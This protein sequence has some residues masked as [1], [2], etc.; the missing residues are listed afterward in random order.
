MSNGSEL[1]HSN[2][3]NLCRIFQKSRAAGPLQAVHKCTHRVSCQ[4]ATD[5]TA[6][7][8]G[9]GPPAYGRK[10]LVPRARL[11]VVPMKDLFRGSSGSA[12][13][14]C[15]CRLKTTLPIVSTDDLQARS[16]GMVRDIQPARCVFYP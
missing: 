6:L 13:P 7:C 4:C 14:G 2:H 12:H 9:S 5:G 3:L 1:L 15:A 11:A 10:P 16:F 8:D